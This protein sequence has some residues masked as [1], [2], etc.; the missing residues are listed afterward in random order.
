MAY[1]DQLSA[2]INAWLDRLAD[3]GRPWVASWIAN[4]IC[5]A[6]ESGLANSEHASFW[7]HCAHAEVRDQ[8]RRC[9]SKRTAPATEDTPAPRFPG[10]DHLQSYYSVKRGDEEIGVPVGELTDEEI[11][12]KAA[13]LRT[14]GAT[15]YAHAN[16]LERFKRR[17]R[18]G[19]ANAA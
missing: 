5:V 12:E 15:C 3:E 16:E 11:D 7:R 17:R 10:F 2:E 1:A 8:V 4:A 13:L 9:M 6:H 18:G 19:A 14:M